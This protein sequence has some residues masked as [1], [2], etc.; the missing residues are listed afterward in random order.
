MPNIA[1][2]RE[3]GV[4][5]V[6]ETVVG[7]LAV[8]TSSNTVLVSNGGTFTQAGNFIDDAQ[9]RPTRAR[10]QRIRG[11]F[12]PGDW[13][14]SS[15]IKPQ[16]PVAGIANNEH[17][18][19]GLMGSRFYNAVANGVLIIRSTSGQFTVGEAITGSVA[20][21]G[22]VGSHNGSLLL[23]SA[24]TVA[25]VANEVVTGGTS[26]AT[27]TVVAIH[28]TSTIFVPTTSL[29]SFSIWANL[30]H[31]VLVN[32]GATVNQAAFTINGVDNGSAD[33]SGQFIK[34]IWTGTAPLGAIVAAAAVTATVTDASLYNVDSRVLLK[35][36]AGTVVDDNGG[37]GYHV[38]AINET[39]N[40]VTIDTA[41]GFAVGSAAT[42]S[43][44]PW[45]PVMV[46]NGT[47]VH[48]RMGSVGL[49]GANISVTD[50]SLTVNNNIQYIVDEKDGSDYPSIYET[51]DPR[52]V[53]SSVGLYFR[54]ADLQYMRTGVV[55]AQVPTTLPLGVTAG[56]KAT[57][58]LP[59]SSLDIPALDA[60]N[61]IKLTTTIRGEASSPEIADD[62]V[63]VF[64]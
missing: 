49:N 4:A 1:L 46:D 51:P 32:I 8:P 15:Y 25:F 30:G 19:D 13:A 11:K 41:G 33:W 38:S 29:N 50:S 26:G 35:N 45:F 12:N 31:S 64:D 28:S 6:P 63:I 18:F 7:T 3:I 14:F 47:I 2:G 61:M 17:L 22:T 16:T 54:E 58:Y 27:A 36:A 34:Q 39:T 60:A 40:V 37:L 53:D 21:A 9:H 23:Q 42:G 55:A 20:G 56:S 43:L 24:L 5:I 52:T 59:N 62:V 48:G 44:A 10:F 57:F